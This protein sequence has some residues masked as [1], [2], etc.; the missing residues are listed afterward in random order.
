MQGLI[1]FY[2]DSIR[3]VIW[4]GHC[5]VGATINITTKPSRLVVPGLEYQRQ[6]RPPFVQRY[7][8]ICWNGFR[9][10][11]TDLL[12]SLDLRENIT[13]IEQEMII[14]TLKK[15]YRMAEVPSHEHK[16]KGGYSRIEL[17][18]VARRYLYSMIK[19]LYF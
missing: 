8:R 10:I 19:Y 12:R 17:K 9:A 1:R 16:S 7:N 4:P 3:P 14:K 18:E 11:R 6:N 13:T 5:D 15:G 2:I